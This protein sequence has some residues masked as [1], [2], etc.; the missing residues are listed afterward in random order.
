MIASNT[1]A[2]VYRHN[3]NMKTGY[4]RSYM[5]SENGM[6]YPIGGTIAEVMVVVVTVAMTMRRT[7]LN[8]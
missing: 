2:K 3:Y 1:L 8:W 4:N 6:Y 7:R 5:G